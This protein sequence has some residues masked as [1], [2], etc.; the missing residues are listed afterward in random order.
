MIYFLQSYKQLQA[1]T[2]INPT[3]PLD[4][5][6]ILL[7]PMTKE[8]LFIEAD[9]WLLL[10]RVNRTLHQSRHII[11]GAELLIC[12]FIRLLLKLRIHEI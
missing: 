6:D 3:I 7:I 2:S 5:L 11:K 1:T 9:S 4:E 8:E 10:L 12:P